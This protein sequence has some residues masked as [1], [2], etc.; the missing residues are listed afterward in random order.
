MLKFGGEDRGP[1]LALASFTF[2]AAGPHEGRAQTAAAE[3]AGRPLRALA[4]RDAMFVWLWV[5]TNG[6]ILG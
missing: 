6:T 3:A 4:L 5:K 2:V 1:Q